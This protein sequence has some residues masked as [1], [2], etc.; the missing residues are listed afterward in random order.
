MLT[1]TPS[2]TSTQTT[3]RGGNSLAPDIVQLTYDHPGRKDAEYQSRRDQIAALALRH[4][5]RGPVPEVAYT[6]I[7]HEVWRTV[8]ESLL[9]L[10]QRYACK[11]YQEASAKLALDPSRLPQLEEV[12]RSLQAASGF[13]MIPV[14]GFVSPRAFMLHLREGTFLSTQ[15]VR[16]PTTPLFSPEPDVIHEL[17]GHACPLMDPRY[18]ALNRR[19][20][21]AAEVV[22][23]DDLLRLGRV[24]WHTLESGMVREK[25]GNKLL[26]AALLSSAQE[27]EHCFSHARQLPFDL[28]RMAA[29]PYEPTALQDEV[30][31]AESFT[32]MIRD[33]TAWLNQLT[34]PW[35]QRATSAAREREMA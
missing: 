11:E 15:Y 33:V 32:A 2:Q 35:R 18:A 19:F 7:E 16:Y 10:H 4:D 21:A 17:L 14:M 13:K 22:N 20:G 23:E 28:D 5:R 27:I 9:P 6:D 8:R 34:A 26:G 25:G 3:L 1:N 31:V 29:S 12:N 24:F 30:Y